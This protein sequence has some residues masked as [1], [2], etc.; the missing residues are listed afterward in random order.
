VILHVSVCFIGAVC[1]CV[2]VG[3]HM[4]MMDESAAALDSSSKQI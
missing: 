2:C 4:N 1:M 3:W